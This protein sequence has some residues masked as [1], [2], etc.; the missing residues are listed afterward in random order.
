M[1]ETIHPIVRILQEDR[2]YKPEAYQF[3]RE[4]LSYAQDVL[5]LGPQELEEKPVVGKRGKAA[6]AE[7]HL[8]GQQLCEAIRLFAISQYGRMA[9][10][11][12]NSWG[13]RSTS[14]FGEVVYNLIKV[15]VMKN[16][17]NDRRE[18]FN[19]CYDF[20]EAFIQGFAF[21]EAT[22]KA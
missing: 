9:K 3:L 11:V 22:E 15:G 13:L 17:E 2:R 16:S 4:A 5:K 12:L 1:S 19:H 20:D 10:A 14:D 7:R 18:D 8:T 6:K 21:S